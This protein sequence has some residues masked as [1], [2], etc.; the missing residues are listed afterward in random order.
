SLAQFRFILYRTIRK[1]LCKSYVRAT[2]SYLIFTGKTSSL[3]AL[4]LSQALENS[5]V[6]RR[7][8]GR[9]GFAHQYSCNLAHH[10][11]RC[12]PCRFS[13]WCPTHTLAPLFACWDMFF[14]LGCF[15]L[16]NQ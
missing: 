5:G 15:G 11:Q 12:S 9:P 8:L 10:L 3:V 1:G 6:L 4:A 16:G 14:P 2:T 7:K 13:P